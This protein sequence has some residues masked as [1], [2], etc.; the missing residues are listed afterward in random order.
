[1]I[2][3][4]IIMGLYYSTTIYILVIVGI[5]ERFEGKINTN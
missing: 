4:I 5:T 2:H 1:M 3:K